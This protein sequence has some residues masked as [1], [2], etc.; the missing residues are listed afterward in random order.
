MR[1]QGIVAKRIEVGEYD[2]LVIFYTQDFGKITAKAKS[3]SKPISKQASHL[4]LFNVVDFSLINGRNHYPIVVSAQSR[5]TYSNLKKSLPAIALGLFLAETIDKIIYDYDPDEALWNFFKTAFDYLDSR[6]P[7][8]DRSGAL[9]I[10]DNFQDKLL[11][12]LGYA[13]K[14]RDASALMKTL[15]QIS[16]R[17][18][19]SLQLIRDVLK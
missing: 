12:T 11:A 1:T 5:Q 3:L 7:S 18:F 14:V 16:H 4:D 8:I 17:Q 9:A 6:A 13:P 19:S 10:L 15:D 2:Q